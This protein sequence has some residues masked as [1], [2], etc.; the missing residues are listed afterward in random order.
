MQPEFFPKTKTC[1]KQRHDLKFSRF[2]PINC[3][4]IT[5]FA[6]IYSIICPIIETVMLTAILLFQAE[7]TGICWCRGMCRE[8]GDM[9]G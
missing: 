3:V 9:K 1:G 6:L 5:L 8:G 2:E 7:E 4:L